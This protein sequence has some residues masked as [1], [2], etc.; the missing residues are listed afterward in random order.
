[1]SIRVMEEGPDLVAP[2][3]RRGEK[4]GSARAEYLVGSRA[5]RNPNA[6]FA[7]DAL[8]VGRRRIGHDRLVFR[9]TSRSRQENLAPCKTHNAE[10][11]GKLTYHCPSQHIPIERHRP[12]LLAAH[13]QPSEFHPTP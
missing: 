4:L 8:V 13:H 2:I 5:V 10:G 3:E 6:Q 11:P 1:M 7:D 12:T 9:G